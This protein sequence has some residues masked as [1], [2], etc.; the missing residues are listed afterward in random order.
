MVWALMAGTLTVATLPV[1][2]PESVVR[3][4]STVAFTGLLPKFAS[5]TSGVNRAPGR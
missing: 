2:G 4:N 1:S 3:E 5:A